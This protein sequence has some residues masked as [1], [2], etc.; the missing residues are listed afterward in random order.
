[1]KRKLFLFIFL[2]SLFLFLF[3]FAHA[4][5]ASGTWGECSWTIDD[6]H[7]M[8]VEP[9]NGVSGR[10]SVINY[11]NLAPWF[12]WVSDIHSFV[13][14]EGV[15]LNMR[16]NYLFSNCVNMVSVDLKNVDFFGVERGS[17]YV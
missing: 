1:M 12:N 17:W 3:C 11:Y 6:D 15:I 10:T 14:R 2:I 9:T 13:F 7:V 16:T 8:T 4:E 5:I